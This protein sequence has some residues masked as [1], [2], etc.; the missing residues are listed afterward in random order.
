[1]SPWPVKALYSQGSSVS[2][3]MSRQVSAGWMFNVTHFWPVVKKSWQTW[4]E[5][6]HWLLKS[7]SRWR[8]SGIELCL[9]S[10]S[11]LPM[12]F[13]FQSVTVLRNNWIVPRNV[14]VLCTRDSDE[15]CVCGCVCE[16]RCQQRR[17]WMEMNVWTFFFFCAF[18]ENNL[19]IVTI[20]ARWLERKMHKQ[21]LQSESSPCI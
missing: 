1:M 8:R 19:T 5:V 2:S 21:P 6:A 7:L 16:K 15:G 9:G 13:I 12:L 18:L 3:Q 10:L 4:G 17:Q 14:N 20:C 11:K